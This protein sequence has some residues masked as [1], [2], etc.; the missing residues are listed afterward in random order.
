[1]VLT[2]V[3]RSLT[4]KGAKYTLFDQ[5]YSEKSAEISAQLYASIGPKSAKYVIKNFDIS[6]R[7]VWGVYTSAKVVVQRAKK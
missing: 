3:P 2:K 6:G 5:Q 1:M 7:T 4:H